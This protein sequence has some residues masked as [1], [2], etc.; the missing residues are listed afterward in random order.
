MQDLKF[1]ECETVDGPMQGPKFS[2]LGRLNLAIPN[3]VVDLTGR[4]ILYYSSVLLLSY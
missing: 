2:R 4:G 3:P 1:D